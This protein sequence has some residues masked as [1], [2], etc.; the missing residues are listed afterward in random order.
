[1]LAITRKPGQSVRIGDAVVVIVAS[2]RKN[3]KLAID[4]PKQVTIVRSE[5]EQR[6]EAA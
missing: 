6:K 2:D 3:V 5:L 1:M 4:A